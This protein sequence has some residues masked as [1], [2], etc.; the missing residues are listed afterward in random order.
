MQVPLHRPGPV[1]GGVAGP[2]DEG[3][4]PV[5]QLQADVPVRQPLDQGGHGDVDDPGNLALRQGREDHNVVHPVD[6]LRP[7]V[8]VQLPPDLVL[9]LRGHG[10][11]GA[12]ALR[13]IGGADVAGHDDDGV[14]EVHGPALV[15]REAA[16]VQQLEQDV[17]HIRV[18]LFNLVKEE[19]AVGP[20]PHGLGELAPLV[21]AHV[22]R[23]RAHQAGNGVLL[24]I[25][26]HVDAD[27]VPLVVKE[28]LGQGLGQLRLA[29]AGGSQ[30]DEG[31]D[32]PVLLLQSRPAPEDGLADGGDRLVLADDPAVED[33]R[34]AQQFL[35]LALHQLAHRNAGPLADHGGDLLLRHLLLEQA[36]L[37]A[38]VHPLPLLLQL[39]LQPGEGV[40]LEP[41]HPLQV[42]A[43]L[44]LLHLMAG[45]LNLLLDPL[46]PG[47]GL[48]LRLPLGAHG[49]VSAPQLRQLPLDVGQ[50][51]FGARV[52]LLAQGLLLD[53]QLHDLA[54]DL[55]QLPGQAVDL[56]ADLAGRLVHQVNGLIR[57][58]PV[59]NIP[60]GEGCA[61]D[62]GGIRNP[63]AVV[64]L[65]ALLQP[66]ENGDGV[67]HRGLV[68]EH[69]LEPALQ[70]GILLNIL[71][72]LV[73][74]GGADA[75]EL[76][77]GQLGLE[78]VPRVHAALGAARAHDV[79][80]LVDK[81]QDPPLALLHLAEHRLQPLLKLPPVLGAR[82]EGP[83]VQGED[84]LV[85]E[86][87]GHVAVED[88]LGQ[89]LHHRGLAHA[90]L[91]DEHG[92]VLGLAAEDLDG[93][94]DLPV[95]ADDRVQLPLPGHLHQI[96]AVLRQ[97]LV[98]L[99]RVLAGDPLAAPDPGEGLKDLLIVDPVLAEDPGA[100][101]AG[102]LGQGQV[103]VLHGHVLVLELPGDPLRLIKQLGEAAAGVELPGSAAGHLGQPINLPL[104]LPGQ[105]L[106]V[107]AHV[108]QQPGHQPLLLAQQGQVEVLPL[109]LLLAV[110]NGDGLAV[111]HRRL[112]V[113]G[114][115]VEI[116]V[117]CLLWA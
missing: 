72:V 92:V 94:A 3:P 110:L 57:Q 11:I 90:G 96:P 41:G 86:P 115:L 17:E 103:Q 114:V 51:V 40:V 78:E 31:A 14:F 66:P 12:D 116:H 35:L 55:V 79:V 93:V 15:V 91:A 6:E 2:G 89:P 62:E 99:L 109:Q 63:H 100:G 69:L 54:A 38:L 61:G 20:A 77:P 1:G 112:S 50:P 39:L 113:L 10:P 95:P 73:Q 42:I 19:H 22:A 67:L 36:L 48:L 32:G 58:E 34:Q 13:E 117:Q 5:R 76:P 16:V 9:H 30:E 27:H 59:R 60:V 87:L 102:L 84:G 70:G 65:K 53:L 80:E 101:G 105:G 33:L 43:P 44:R 75:V 18:G 97:G 107:Q 4:G 8:L 108:G 24:H 52:L 46:H 45:V 83:H 111:R 37:L 81:Q 49:V 28:G 56:H 25:L 88:P 71:A 23:R 68:N 85:L 29:H 82:D 74:G 26:R 47:N 64:N 104:D 98:A 106:H 21:V 7:E